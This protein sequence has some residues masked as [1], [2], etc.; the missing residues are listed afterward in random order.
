MQIEGW[1]CLMT[2]IADGASSLILRSAVS[3]LMVGASEVG[4][5]VRKV[6][7][8]VAR[9]GAEVVGGPPTALYDKKLQ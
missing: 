7:P 8:K 2:V 4:Q 5:I 1:W 3:F 6:A 9:L